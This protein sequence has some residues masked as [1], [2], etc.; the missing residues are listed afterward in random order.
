MKK[1]A[2]CLALFAALWS[3]SACAEEKTHTNSIDM[4]FVFIPPG[5]FIMGHAGSAQAYPPHQVTIS[6]PFY[7]GRYPVTQKQWEAVMGK[8]PS[9]FKGATNPVENVSWDDVQT[10]I[11]R[12]NTKEGHTLY[13]LPTE[14]EWEHAARAG[15]STPWFFSSAHSIKSSELWPYA[16]FDPNAGGKTHPV[17]KK[18]PNQWGLYDIYG[19]VNEWVQDRMPLLGLPVGPV[20]DPQGPPENQSNPLYRV[21]RGGCYGDGAATSNSS[22]RGVAEPHKRSSLRG[23][24]LALSLEDTVK[25]P[26][27]E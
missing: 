12:L 14:A 11:A 1:I 15:T 5:S 17:G 4:E 21:T 25:S 16:W 2:F 22:I 27:A 3:G 7:L 26:P 8:N 18:K 23:F 20:I 6:K 24:R 9:R 13:R 19:N 10:F